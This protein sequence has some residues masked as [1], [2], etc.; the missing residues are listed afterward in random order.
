M[1]HSI[2]MRIRAV[3]TQPGD[4]SSNSLHSLRCC[5]CC[6]TTIPK[7]TTQS[8]PDTKKNS[9]MCRMISMTALHY[10][11]R[12]GTEKHDDLPIT[13]DRIHPQP[14]CTQQYTMAIRMMTIDITS[15]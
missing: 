4:A 9:G 15:A 7:R 12:R 3:S 14:L 5:S 8:S 10:D 6:T 13:H 11:R 1:I 2:M